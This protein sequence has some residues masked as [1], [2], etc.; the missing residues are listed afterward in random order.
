MGDARFD[1]DGETVAVT[2]GSSG[3]GRAIALAFG[4]A[5]ATVLN[6][7]V[8][9]D[10][11]VGDVPTHRHIREEGGDAEFLETDVSDPEQLL[12][13][14]DRA[15]ELGGLDVFVNNA[16]VFEDVPFLGADE[17]TLD[18]HYSVNVKGVYFGCQAAARH[19]VDGRGAIVNVASISSRVAQGG[20]VHYEAS[21]GAVEMVTRGV[22]FELA[23]E[24]V[25]VNAVAPGIVPTELYEGYSERYRTEEE[26][27]ELVKPI[28]MGRPGTPEEVADAALFLASD[29]A[30]YTTGETLFVDGGW[31]VI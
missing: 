24:G 31:M 3:I 5:G 20:L 15:A 1:F 30:G 16:G 14:A 17:A 23:G 19:M 22:A 26:R 25:R 13:L 12:A 10:P 18:G 2:G 11:K 27:D 9:P 7:D 28:P 8:R 29:A 21:K 6:G 4:A